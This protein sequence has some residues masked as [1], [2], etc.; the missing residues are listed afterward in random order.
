MA[1]AS[2]W[3]H[4]KLGNKKKDSKFKSSRNIENIYRYRLIV[5]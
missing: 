4:I 1:F 2:D 5:I 3:E